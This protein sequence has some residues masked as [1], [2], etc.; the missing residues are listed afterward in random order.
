MQNVDD[1]PNLMPVSA[2]PV[3]QAPPP[4]F[5]DSSDAQLLSSMIKD[6]W[7][8]LSDED[9]VA[10]HSQPDHFYRQLQDK[11]GLSREQADIDLT[12]MRE[13]GRGEGREEAA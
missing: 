4:S 12:S 5:M 9:V 10:Y 6:K 3:E 13:R 11:Y 2:A 7:N 1:I 8:E